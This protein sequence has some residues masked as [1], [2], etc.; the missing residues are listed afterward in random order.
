MGRKDRR[1]SPGSDTGLAVVVLGDEKSRDH[2]GGDS[3]AGHRAE[4]ILTVLAN[5]PAGLVTESLLAA[6]GSRGG[7]ERQ[8][9]LRALRAL[10]AGGRLSIES[11]KHRSEIA[12]ALVVPVA[13]AGQ[14]P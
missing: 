12:T 7:A 13:R 14:Y 11:K 2:Q 1:R 5:H 3:M 10:E 9:M 6:M 8:L 4:R